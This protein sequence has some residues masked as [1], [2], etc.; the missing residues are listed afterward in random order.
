MLE[1]VFGAMRHLN[2]KSCHLANTGVCF[3][4]VDT[5]TLTKTLSD[6]PSFKSVDE[7]FRVRLNLEDKTSVNRSDS[8]R[9]FLKL[10]N[11]IVL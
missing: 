3:N 4:V 5:E 9:K 7:S 6:E 8:R 11:A 10:V 1:V 2:T